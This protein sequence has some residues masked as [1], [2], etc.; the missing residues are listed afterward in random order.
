MH[1]YNISK[2]KIGLIFLVIILIII[3]SCLQ[4]FEA[5]TASTE[6]VEFNNLTE[7]FEFVL[8]GEVKGIKLLTTGVLVVGIENENIDIEIGDII[9]KVDNVSIESNDGLIEYINNKKENKDK[10][11]L[12]VERNKKVIII[13][14]DTIYV[15]SEEKYELGLW[16]K[17]SSAGVGTITF[18][19]KNKLLF[20][21]LGHGISETKDNIIIPIINGAIVKS[22]VKGINKGNNKSPGDIRGILYKDVV[23]QITKNTKNGIYGFLENDNLIKGKETVNVADKNE[24]KEGKAYIYCALDGIN[25]KKYEIV[26]EKI[27][28]ESNSNKNM[29]VCVTDKELL[30]KTGGI[31]QGM[32]GSPIV[33]NGKLIGAITHVFLNDSTRGYG[34]FIQNMIKDI[35]DI[36]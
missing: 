26:I 36:K 25:V 17:D 28:Y 9:L 31:I 35:Q 32:S 6:T 15:P 12:T 21:G 7:N 14:A 30:D 2:R 10:V 20:G 8:G 3:Y 13:E 33:Q 27:L 22:E 24:I 29:F 16:V 4:Y 18:Y 5:R 11:V 34:V 1:V 23:G 19:E